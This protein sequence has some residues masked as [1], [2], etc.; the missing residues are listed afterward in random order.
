MRF[1]VQAYQSTANPKI[2]IHPELIRLPE[3]IA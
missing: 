3:K 1:I 2:S